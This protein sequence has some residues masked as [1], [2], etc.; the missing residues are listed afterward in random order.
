LNAQLSKNLNK[1]TQLYVGAENLTDFRQKNLIIDP[2]NPTGQFFDASL[3]WGPVIGRM[4]Y[5]G[6]R[7]KWL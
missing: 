7:W 6:F 5:A 1:A 3:V 2:E 4:V